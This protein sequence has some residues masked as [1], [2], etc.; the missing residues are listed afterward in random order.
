MYRPFESGLPS[1]T[2]RV[3][4]HEIP[5]GQLSNLRQQAIALGL[6]DKFEAIE[7]MYAAADKIL[8]RPTKV[9][10][11]SKVVGDL[12]LHLVA[13]GADP[14]EFTEQP[15]KFD[16]PDSVIGFLNG[17]LGTPEGGWPEPFRT[18]ALE[19]RT[20]PI[21][22]T[23]VSESDLELLNEPGTLR[24]HTLNRLLF[25]GP[26]KQFQDNRKEYGDLSTLP[27]LPYLYGLAPGVEYGVQ[28]TK[29]V[30]LLVS[31]KAIGEPDQ[32]A[33]RTVMCQLNGQLR[34]MRVRDESIDSHIAA[35]ER[36]NPN[37]AGHVA[38]PYA[39]AVTV[40]V[41]EGDQVNAGQAVATIEA[42]KMEAAINAPVAGIVQRIVLEDTTQLEGGDLVLV[43]KQN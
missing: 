27:T 14:K 12:A 2:G 40:M 20:K 9:T 8:G 28:L 39:G 11:S 4:T 36:A 31:L 21:R 3:Y 34:P 5:G 33:N 19:G 24:Q 26:T 22:I 10:P 23:E 42:M 15:N 35:A 30:R 18:K 43:I 25:P 6:G 32:R 16:V 1:P 7:E 41:D 38:A 37:N 29:G 13:V 17:E